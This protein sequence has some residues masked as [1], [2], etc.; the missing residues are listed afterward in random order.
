MHN[1]GNGAS[2]SHAF[3]YV[4]RLA[5]ECRLKEVLNGRSLTQLAVVLVA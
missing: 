1:I 2:E 4:L 5:H 3:E